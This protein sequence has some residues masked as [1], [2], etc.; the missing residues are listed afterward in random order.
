[1]QKK[2]RVA[3]PFWRGWVDLFK[4][5]RSS[6]G[7]SFCTLIWWFINI[8][9]NYVQ[10]KPPNTQKYGAPKVWSPS[11]K[12]LVPGGSPVERSAWRVIAATLNFLVWCDFFLTIG[13][14]VNVNEIIIFEHI[15]WHWH[16]KQIGRTCSSGRNR[17]QI[18][19]Q[20]TQM[21]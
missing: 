16:F 13:R 14:N 8:K 11:H 1:M 6:V 7:W 20:R 4:G 3:V 17:T 12:L 21:N 19:T 10:K 2:S 18:R 9:Y 15:D 5:L